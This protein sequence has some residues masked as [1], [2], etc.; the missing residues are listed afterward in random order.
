VPIGPNG[1][2]LPY[3]GEP[4]YGEPPGRRK[5]R[6]GGNIPSPQ[7]MTPEQA[8]LRALLEQMGGS[9]GEPPNQTRT[10]QEMGSTVPG[11]GMN[12]PAMDINDAFFGPD[13]KRFDIV[14]FI[15]NLIGGK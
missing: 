5:T 3:P 7:Q 2:R 10:A 11:E 9:S 6:F 12:R 8:Q 15:T 13:R 1:E 14:E 4:G